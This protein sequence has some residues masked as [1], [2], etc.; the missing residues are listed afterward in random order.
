M[1]AKRKAFSLLKLIAKI[2]RVVEKL[3][4]LAIRVFALG[5]LLHQLYKIVA[6][7]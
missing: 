3:E 7:H 5:T 6:Q 1:T 2:D 4:V